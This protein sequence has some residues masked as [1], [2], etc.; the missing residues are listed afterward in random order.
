MSRP[1]LTLALAHLAALGSALA[2]AAVAFEARAFPQAKYPVTLDQVRH[3]S[4]RPPA[5]DSSQP[6]VDA[7][8]PADTPAPRPV[9]K[10]VQAAG[11]TAPKPP[12]ASAGAWSV[13]LV[14]SRDTLTGVSRRFSVP[15]KTLEDINEL[16]PKAGLRA[17]ARLKLPPGTA[18]GGKDPYASGPTPAALA[19]ASP[20]APH[21]LAAA[22]TP[23]KGVKLADKE[24]APSKAPAVAPAKPVD[25]SPT[26]RYAAETPPPR[27]ATAAAAPA[28]LAAQDHSPP[29][30][31]ESAASPN[32]GAD[33]LATGRGRFVWPIRGEIVQRFG[34][35]G[36]GQRNDGVDIAASLGAQVV[37]A[38]EGVVVYA[39]PVRDFGELVLLKH[40]DGWV[41]AYANLSAVSVR[42]RD[43]VA[44]GQKLG[45]TGAGDQ[46]HLHFEVR[47]APEPK[48]KARPIDPLALLPH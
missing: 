29:P 47:Y 13:Y 25:A 28:A 20:P 16:E 4:S 46:P 2:L 18:D 27:V 35:Q 15:V 6:A 34:P 42:I 40:A 1:P 10:P 5:A 17:G 30:S 23:A 9:P 12:A 24:P 3:A 32:A 44:Q 33:A 8:I 36:P 7:S 39:G 19:S 11:V 22:K 48:E 26:P 43:H 14:Q 37:A 21:R 41:T 45:T 38:A 31:S